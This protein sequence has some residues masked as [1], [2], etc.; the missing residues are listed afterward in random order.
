MNA[1]RLWRW[2]SALAALL[3]LGALAGRA[4][5]HAILLRSNPAANADLTAPPA[6]I[7]LWFTEALETDFSTARLVDTT[8]A[9]VDASAGAPVFDAADPTHLSLPVGRLEPGVY[10]VVWQTLS[11]VDGHEWYGSFPFTVLN[12]DGSR[13]SGTAAGGNENGRSELPSPPEAFFRWLALLGAALLWGAPLFRL[14]AGSEAAPAKPSK[15]PP[16]EAALATRL[17]PLARWAVWAAVGLLLVGGLGQVVV[18]SLRLGSLTN[19]PKVL[20][21]TRGGLL[22]LVRMTPALAALALTLTGPGRARAIMRPAWVAAAF[23]GLLL[24]W[25]AAQGGYWLTAGWAA[26]TVGLGLLLAWRERTTT[27]GWLGWLA[28][29]LLALGSLGGYSAASHAAAVQGRGWAV[30]SDYA[31]LLAAGT[32]LGGLLLLPWLLW[33]ERAVSDPAARPAAWKLARRYSYLASLSV[34]VLALTGLVNSLVQLP[35]LASL[36]GTAYGRV[37]L[38]KLGVLGAAMLLALLNN[39]LLHGRR[40]PAAEAAALNQLR[41]QAWVEAGVALGLMLMVAVLV[42]TSTPRFLAPATAYTP[43]LPFTTT[44]VADDLNL[45]VQ[46][47]PNVVGDNKFWLHLYHGD[48]T[49]VGEVQL[50][51]LRFNYLNAQ[52]GQASVDLNALGRATFEAGGA[53]LSQSG[54]WALSV[55]IR[56]RGLDDVLTTFNVTVPAPT[57][58]AGGSQW[59]ANPVPGVPGLVIAALV[60]LGLGLAPIIWRRP[61]AGLGARAR[62]TATIAG[63]LSLTVALGFSVAGAPAWRDQ[64]LA[65]QAANRTNPIP[66]SA[67]SLAAGKQLF[68]E[69][70]APCHGPLGLGDGPVGL[71]LRPAPAN[72][73]VHM[74]PGVHTDAQIFDWISNGFPDSQMPAFAT[75]LTEDERWHILNY[76]RTLV[77]PDSVVTPPAQ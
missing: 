53:Y 17:T 55:Y 62:S 52:L 27:V 38:L 75:V 68:A 11:Q 26:L 7:D 20:L 34:F 61:L 74:V 51:Q 66:A 28:L 69:N 29:L 25:S 39:R 49:S 24:L 72:L 40:K 45:H 70:C 43:Q 76:I 16:A 41:R 58:V 60:L 2:A 14:L 35:D 1:R 10:T 56:R 46:I 8:G 63:F 71:T 48:S 3:L 22:A 73:Q 44:L 30:L 13:P 65:Q 6:F 12:A 5:A 15:R 64:I 36:W 50:V 33:R 77:P 42:Q 21:D 9:Q 54:P 59:W 19:L 31:H 18:Q 47:T 23:C 37:L 57:N 4:Q 67:E 32:W